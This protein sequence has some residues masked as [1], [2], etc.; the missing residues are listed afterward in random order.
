MD[1]VVRGLE[2]GLLIWFVL[3]AMIIGYRVLSG[4]IDTTG[5]L[6]QELGNARAAPE[7]VVSMAAFPVVIISY[8]ASALHADVS[9]VH[10]SLPDLSEKLLMLLTGG[11]GIYLTGKIARVYRRTP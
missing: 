7:R 3:L 6:S 5:L 11:N 2:T 9:A 10:P 1:I 8:A 4:D